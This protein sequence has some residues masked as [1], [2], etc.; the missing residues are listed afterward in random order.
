MKNDSTSKKTISKNPNDRVPL[1]AVLSFETDVPVST[2]VEVNDGVKS[3]KIDFPMASGKALKLPIVGMRANRSHTFR[4][5][6]KDA[7][8]KSF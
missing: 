1:A 8:Q 7:A 4:I 2:L 3:W 6:V 5:T